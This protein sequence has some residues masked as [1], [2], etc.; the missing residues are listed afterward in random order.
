VDNV[1]LSDLPQARNDR[2]E[3]LKAT[4]QINKVSTIRLAD[5]I[6]QDAPWNVTGMTSTLRHHQVIAAG[7]MVDWENRDSN[8]SGTHPKGGI[9]ADDMGLGMNA[10]SLSLF[11]V[12]KLRVKR[13]F[14]IVRAQVFANSDQVKLFRLSH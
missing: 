8:G 13:H 1:H 10:R 11:H 3:L 12:S 5:N 4:K 6:N 9:L 7:T 2:K 14:T